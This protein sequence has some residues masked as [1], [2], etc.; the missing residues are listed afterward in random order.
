MSSSIDIILK[1]KLS[2]V[3]YEHVKKYIET[4]ETIV[5]KTA[6]SVSELL[7]P[8]RKYETMILYPMYEAY[9]DQCSDCI[10]EEEEMVE[11]LE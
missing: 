7:D 6:I 9:D 8:L 10:I 4:L 1:R 5:Q 3:E 2:H 11:T